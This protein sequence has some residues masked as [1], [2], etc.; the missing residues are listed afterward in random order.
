MLRRTTTILFATAA[1]AVAPT[2]GAGEKGYEKCSTETTAC[3]RQ[4]AEEAAKRGWIG[5]E[6]ESPADTTI[7]RVVAGGPAEQA[8]V[9]AGDVWRGLDDFRFADLEMKEAMVRVKK[10][11]VPGARVIFH[12]ERNG[13]A[14]ALPIEPIKVPQHILAQWVGQHVLEG[15]LAADEPA[16]TEE[17]P[18]G[19]E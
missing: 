6:F 5:I 8:G 19:G 13:R 7:T 12:L 2:A 17:D 10:T 16:A 14:L 15:H 4:M 18:A 11:L 9:R 1:L 3:I